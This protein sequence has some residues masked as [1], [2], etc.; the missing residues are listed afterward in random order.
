MTAGLAAAGA[1]A[2]VG[3]TV[4]MEPGNLHVTRTRVR[5]ARLPEGPPVRILHLSDLHVS[6]VVSDGLIDR[7]VSLGLRERPHVA[8]LTGDFW[9]RRPDDTAP[10]VRSLRRLSATAPCFACAGNH[11]GGSWVAPWGGYPDL[12]PLRNVL[13]EA[14]VSLLHNANRA[15]GIAGRRIEL[16]GV[17][18]LWTDQFDPASAF[19]GLDEPGGGPRIVLCHNPDAKES[20]G[21]YG[22]DLMLC[23]HT[24]GGQLVVPF[25]GWRPF[26]P[27][28][29][30]RHMEGLREWAGRP[31]FV[32]RGVGNLHGMR[33][34]CPPEVS[35][36]EIV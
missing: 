9:S 10:L 14:G 11:D 19:A 26:A 28:R 18:D 30:R 23:G 1:S 15:I 36:V 3:H 35:L 5:L 24:H 33:F 29:D 27:V 17:G 7:A 31:V 13:D 8:V 22:W 25:L 32:T 4:L 21:G 6:P 12:D 34:N 20:L 16:V 2:G